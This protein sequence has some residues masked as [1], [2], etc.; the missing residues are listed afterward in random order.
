MGEE[1]RKIVFLEEISKTRTQEEFC[2]VML[3]DM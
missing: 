1:E 2:K 3:H